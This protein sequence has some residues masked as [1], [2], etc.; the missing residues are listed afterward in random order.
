MTSRPRDIMS[1]ASRNV[2][3]GRMNRSDGAS[4]ATVWAAQNPALGSISCVGVWVSGLNAG[5]P[6][7]AYIDWVRFGTNVVQPTLIDD[8]G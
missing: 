4:S 6:G 5:V 1:S 2:A 3:G 8:L 7:D